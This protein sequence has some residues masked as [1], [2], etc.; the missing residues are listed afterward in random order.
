MSSYIN[1]AKVLDALVCSDTSTRKRPEQAMPSALLPFG[2]TVR[3]RDLNPLIPAV[4]LL[5]CALKKVAV[6]AGED[7]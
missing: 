5:C 4:T 1:D 3:Y 6:H 2:A 7:R